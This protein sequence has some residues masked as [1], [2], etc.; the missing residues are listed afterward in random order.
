MYFCNYEECDVVIDGKPYRFELLAEYT[1]VYQKSHLRGIEFT[2]EPNTLHRL[3]NQ[4]KDAADKITE[5]SGIKKSAYIPKIAKARLE[6]F[7]FVKPNDIHG[8][9]E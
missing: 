9:R 4:E 1:K 8:D 2:D 5:E 7:S 3:V 6:L